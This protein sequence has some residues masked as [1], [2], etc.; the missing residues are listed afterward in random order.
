MASRGAIKSPEQILSARVIRIAG[1]DEL[2]TLPG[3]QGPWACKRRK[4]VV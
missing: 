4:I 2:K 1:A 3:R